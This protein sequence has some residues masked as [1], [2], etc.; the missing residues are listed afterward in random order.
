MAD[1]TYDVGGAPASPISPQSP[2]Q[3]TSRAVGI[4]FIGNALGTLGEAAGN[5]M[6]IKEKR[7]EAEQEALKN[8]ALSDFSAEQLKIVDAVETGAYGSAEARM[9]MRKNLS[10]YIA[11][12]PAAAG[13][14]SKLHNSLI[15]S[16]GLGN[17]ITEGTQEEIQTRAI[18]DQA[19]KAGWIYPTMNQ[20]Q[21]SEGIA[22]YFRFNQAKTQL[23]IITKQAQAQSAQIGVTNARLTT[24]QKQQ[25][26]ATG[27]ITQQ[28]AKI[29]LNLKQT[30][31]ESRNA[32]YG[33][34]GSLSQKLAND[35]EAIRLEV[36]AGRMTR[37]QAVMSANQ[38]IFEI[39]QFGSQVG[40][41]AGADFIN[42]LS[43]PMKGLAQNYTD[44]F[45][46][47]TTLEALNNSNNIKTATIAA[48]MNQDPETATLIATS[49]LF[50]QSSILTQGQIGQIVIDTVKRAEAGK[51]VDLTP[52][53]EQDKVE[54]TNY[55]T[56]LKDN[57][58]AANTGRMTGP[59]GQPVI[60]DLNKHFEQVISGI[61]VYQGAA[62]DAS[63]YSHVIDFLADTQVNKYAVGKGGIATPEAASQ[64][65]D[66]L[67]YQYQNSLLPMVKEEW[68][69]A[70]LS[71]QWVVSPD[72][73]RLVQG[74]LPVGKVIYPEFT[75]SGIV[76]KGSGAPQ[77]NRKTKEL[78]SKLAPVL[79]KMIRAQATLEG[80][81]DFKAIYERDYAEQ[82]FGKGDV[83]EDQ[84]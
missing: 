63:Q 40:A 48:Q 64:A 55:L 52:D 61:S 79:N 13:D 51:P 34:Q 74:E 24:Q 77:I 4:E 6:Q 49:K 29:N 56:M 54:M 58:T 42:A 47:K 83:S 16:S 22:A 62:T 43:A 70:K 71:D 2:V 75:G 26:L 60:D 44:Y 78:N 59:E 11:N 80:T 12:N 50:P 69:K 82:L 20:Q 41:A 35:M 25:S 14:I 17:V 23:D 36:D 53:F 72:R 7:A 73:G 9:R 18:E 8:Q 30:Q 66:V 5:F 81:S 1:F 21:K 45:S 37:E 32:L 84:K 3:D 76:F 68:E 65:L 10:S 38:K 67:T 57:A 31:M 28:T 19:L 15:K 27:A 39:E 33:V 46:G